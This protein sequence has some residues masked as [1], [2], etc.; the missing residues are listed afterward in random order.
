MWSAAV[1]DGI[2]ALRLVKTAFP[3]HS[4]NSDAIDAL[5]TVHFL[6]LTRRPADQ[7]TDELRRWRAADKWYRELGR[8]LISSKY[9][10]RQYSDVARFNTVGR[11]ANFDLRRMLVDKELLVRAREIK[12]STEYRDLVR[13]ATLPGSDAISAGNFYRKG[14]GGNGWDAYRRYLETKTS[15]TAIEEAQLECIRSPLEEVLLAEDA[16]TWVGILSWALHFGH[17]PVPGVEVTPGGDVSRSRYATR[18]FDI[19]LS[20]AE[21]DEAAISLLVKMITKDKLFEKVIYPKPATAVDFSKGIPPSCP[22]VNNS[23][24]SIGAVMLHRGKRY[25]ATLLLVDDASYPTF[26]AYHHSSATFA[27]NLYE[28]ALARD[29]VLLPT[30]LYAKEGFGPGAPR[31]VCD[32]E[33]AV[34]RKLGL[35]FQTPR[36]RNADLSEDSIPWMGLTAEQQQKLKDDA[37]A[38]AKEQKAARAAKK[39]EGAAPKRPRSPSTTDQPPSPVAT[40]K[41]KRK[42]AT[43]TSPIPANSRKRTL[44]DGELAPVVEKK[45]KKA[46]HK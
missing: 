37:K 5:S 10:V 14:Q 18:S 43:V 12:E 25:L 46:A 22:P 36:L 11:P 13:L 1:A 19:I 28:A 4:R 24:H 7:D 45:G 42:A 33:K 40:K 38:K 3:F 35:T 15:R 34:W 31:I 30:G 21:W 27:G 20:R 26:L 44:D 8:G 41:A 39:A 16:M 2:R 29:Y 6:H 32:D 23:A 9:E 17:Y